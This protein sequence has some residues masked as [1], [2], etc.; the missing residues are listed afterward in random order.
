MEKKN[1]GENFSK[2][3]PLEEVINSYTG[4]QIQDKK[5]E[6]VLIL[7]AEE[8]SAKYSRIGATNGQFIAGNMTQKFSFLISELFKLFEVKNSEIEYNKKYFWELANAHIIL[9]NAKRT[10]EYYK[11]N[12]SIAKNSKISSI[13]KQKPILVTE[14]TLYDYK[15]SRVNIN[16]YAYF[17]QEDLV[18]D[19]WKLGDRY[20]D[21][22]FVTIKGNELKS[23]C[24]KLEIQ[25]NSSSESKSELLKK[26]EN[27]FKGS[28]CF[29]NVKLF[30]DKN[31]ISFEQKVNHDER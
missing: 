26:L 19:Y 10:K 8:Y 3:T 6:Y 30:L 2:K 21:E 25:F 11:T 24:R 27:I 5:F 4:I 31:Q 23:L 28:D 20:E 17:D 29:L 22:Y 14:V 1:F 7:M 16:S 13:P 18:I 9:R 15:D 12:S